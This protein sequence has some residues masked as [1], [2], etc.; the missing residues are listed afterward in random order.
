[1]LSLGVSLPMLLQGVAPA[2]AASLPNGIT[3]EVVEQGNVR[4]SAGDKEDG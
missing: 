4:A 3:Y 2:R 1:M